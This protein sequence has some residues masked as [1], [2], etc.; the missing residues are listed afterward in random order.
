[1]LCQVCLDGS[2]GLEAL[3][4]LRCA[5]TLADIFDARILRGRAV[6]HALGLMGTLY[7]A[8]EC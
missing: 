3:L 1:M 6:C 8:A 7:T 5:W 4:L 2:L